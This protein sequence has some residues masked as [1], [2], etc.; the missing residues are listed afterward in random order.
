MK[1][2]LYFVVVL[3]GFFSFTAF[4]WKNSG[5]CLMQ[6]A[7]P[8][9]FFCKL[10]QIQQPGRAGG[11][12]WCSLPCAQPSWEGISRAHA[13]THLWRCTYIYKYIY[14]HMCMYM[15]LFLWNLWG[16]AVMSCCSWGCW[17]SRTGCPLHQSPPWVSPWMLCPLLPQHPP[18]LSS[19]PKKIILVS[20]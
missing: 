13:Q 7:F 10:G 2:P 6:I 17:S 3:F 9:I 19:H 15:H 1:P 5:F 14:T 12:G 11:G 20:S 18:Q 8:P 16:W 4:L